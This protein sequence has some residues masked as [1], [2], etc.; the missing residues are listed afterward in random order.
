MLTYSMRRYLGAVTRRLQVGAGEQGRR[1]CADS[2]SARDDPEHTRTL[3]QL[4]AARHFTAGEPVDRESVLS[5]RLGYGPLGTELKKNLLRQWWR[6]VVASR[7]EV[8][9]ISSPHQCQGRPASGS[10]RL[11][12]GEALSSVLRQKGLSTEGLAREVE[13]TLRESAVLRTT[14]LPGALDQYMASLELVNKKLPFGLAEMGVCYLPPG[15]HSPGA[16][17]TET[18]LVWFCSPRTAAQWLDYW[19]RHRLQWWRKF[20]VGP[21]NFVSADFEEEGDGGV[22]RAVRGARLLYHFPWGPEPLE[23]LRSLG[24]RELLRTHQG[25][26]AKLQCLDGRRC[27]VPHVVSVSGNMDRAM[28]A[29]L[30]DSLQQQKRVDSRQRLHHRKVLKLHPSL[31][32]VKVALDMSRGPTVELRQ[33]C[34][35][36]LQELLDRSISVWP[37]YLQ[38]LPSSLEQL[39]KKYDEM[40]V[41]FTVLVSEA[42][43]ENGL[44]QVRNRDTTVREMMHVSEIKDFLVKYVTESTSD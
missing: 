17:V 34:E 32:P 21:S 42:T 7:A 6:S 24:D 5:G 12:D 22:E 33:V 13:R 31:A 39:H 16:E 28:L 40:G 41:L 2:A 27:V 10:L 18:S 25:S 4:C 30:H 29:Y 8:L 35:G 9:G 43:L 3:L 26:K 15:G 37:G 11:V 1:G 23:T 36:L 38:T 20:A 14:L 19:V 44:V